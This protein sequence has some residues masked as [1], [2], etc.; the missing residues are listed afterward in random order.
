MVS[1]IGRFHCISGDNKVIKGSKEKD[2]L[3]GR[4]SHPSVFSKKVLL[5][6]LQIHRK[7]P[8]SYS[9]FKKV[10]GLQPGTLLKRHS[11]TGVFI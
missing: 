8:M 6:I 11:G 9:L 3:K 5:K 7:R 4:D 1:T 2:S 10:K